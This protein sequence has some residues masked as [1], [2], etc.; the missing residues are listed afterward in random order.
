M[1]RWTQI[2]ASQVRVGDTVS[3]SMR[4]SDCDSP[5]QHGIITDIKREVGSNRIICT[6]PKGIHVWYLIS[7]VWRK[8]T[9]NG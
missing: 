9:S 7:R 1:S 6:E 2:Y 8:E 5:Y 3:W 4:E